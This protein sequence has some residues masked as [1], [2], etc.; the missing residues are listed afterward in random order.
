MR[1]APQLSAAEITEMRKAATTALRNPP[2]S[3]V[4]TRAA[5]MT[6]RTA[7]ITRENSPNVTS[8]SG[9]ES[10][11]SRGPTMAL[12]TPNRA[13][14]P[15][16]VSTPPSTWTDGTTAAV[17][18]KAMAREIHTTA[19]NFNIGVS[20][21][22]DGSG[23]GRGWTAGPIAGSPST[24]EPSPARCG[25][26]RRNGRRAMWKQRWARTPGAPSTTC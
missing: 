19:M 8:I 26:A 23:S 25:D 14:R 2:T 9:S 18:P 3:K 16:R 5:V 7:L 6:R 24:G 12:T 17:I 10:S 1:I 15:S 4:S 11:R 20:P 22:P 13:A 21:R